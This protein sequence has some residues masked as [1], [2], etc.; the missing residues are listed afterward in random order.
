VI[1]D[2]SLDQ[3]IA[4]STVVLVPMRTKG[5]SRQPFAL[6]TLKPDASHGSRRLFPGVSIHRFIPRMHHRVPRARH[7]TVPDYYFPRKGFQI[8]EIAS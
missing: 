2:L 5:G 8:C 3:I 4:P 6:S 1:D 7:C